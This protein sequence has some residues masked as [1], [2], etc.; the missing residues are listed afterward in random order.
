MGAVEAARHTLDILR[1]RAAPAAARQAYCRFVEGSTGVFWRLIRSYYRHSFRE[2][3]MN[4][5]GPLKVHAAV[6][7]TLAG[8]VFPKPVWPLRWRLRFFDL[9]VLL[10]R[11]VPLC[12]RRAECS[13]LAET[14]VQLEMG[15]PAPEPVEAL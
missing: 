13:L 14:P 15:R 2:L 5:R 6:I 10:Q 8:Q 11:F 1:G 7:S 9:C 4:G 3:F 12:P